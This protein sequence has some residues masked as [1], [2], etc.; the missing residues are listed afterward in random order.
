MTY[1][2]AQLQSLTA[3]FESASPQAVLRWAAETF[4]PRLAVV[5]SFQHTG[6]VT[7]HMLQDIAPATPVLT[8]DTGN[9]FPETYALIDEVEARF[10][11]NLHR[12]RPADDVPQD[13][14]RDDVEACCHQRKVVPLREAL[15]GYDA[16]VTGVRRDQSPTRADTPVIS[17][18]NAHEMVKIAPFATWTSDMITTYV[19]AHN[20]PYNALYDAG[21]TSIGCWPCTR[22]VNEGEDDRAGRWANSAKTEC[23][24]H[25]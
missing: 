18:D 15:R 16:W 17:W 6:M 9:L 5:T 13:L 7:L 25:L 23:G 20:L 10:N 22:P 11:L 2:D 19:S 3:D 24:I 4:G 21:Y 12:I 1:T 14:W 8:V